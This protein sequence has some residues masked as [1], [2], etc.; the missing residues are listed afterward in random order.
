MAEGQKID[1]LVRQGMKGQRDALG[2]LARNVEGRV[3]AYLCRVTLSRALTEDL[4]QEVLLTM[5]SSLG[6]LKD[7]DRFWPWLYRIAQSKIQQHFRTKQRHPVAPESRLYEELVARR[8]DRHQ[9]DGLKQL[10]HKD[11]VKKTLAAM[12]Q[13]S[14]PHRAV[15]SLRCFDELSYGDIAL[16][17][18]CSEVKARVLFYRAKEALK[19]QL[20]RQGVKKSM[21]VLC[22]GLFGKITAPAD[23]AAATVTVAAG[24]MKAGLT[25]ALLANLT[26]KTVV[27]IVGAITL[28]TATVGTVS[29]LSQP[30][31]TPRQQVTS[32]HFTTQLRFSGQGALSSLS[33]GAYEQW[34]H[35][36]AGVD[37]PVFFRMQR[38]DPLQKNKLCAWLQDGQANYYF[39][40]G[41]KKLYLSND[42][43]CWSCLKVRRL[44]TDNA[45]FTDFLDS[46]EGRDPKLTYRRDR[47]SGLLLAAV[48]DRFADARHFRTTYEY[49]TA[50]PNAFEPNW[51]AGTPVVDNRDEMHRRGWT[52]FTIRGRLGDR[53]V[54]GRGR[55]PFVYDASTEHPAWMI[56]EAGQTRIV[57]GSEIARVENTGGGAPIFYPGGSFFAGLARPWMGLHCVDTVRRDAVRQRIAFETGKAK[58][59]D[60]A[61]VTLTHTVGT[62]TVGLTYV[63]AMDTDVVDEIRFAINRRPAG[64]LRFSYL[65][66]IDA[67]ADQFVEPE[68]PQE[69]STRVAESPGL[70][71]LIDLALGQVGQQ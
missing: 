23:A 34:F 46:M 68:R 42:R 36:P 6:D 16:T 20:G 47:R 2:Q 26:I 58:H 41:T 21:L 3:S 5:V 61:T 12:R 7:P 54:S 18:N 49:N 24:S 38:W 57:D 44:P 14:E 9:H 13:L 56:L 17:M 1:I 10:M 51:P 40:S 11:L 28:G 66:E 65:Q 71:W 39:E 48:D 37:G 33:K 52:F 19:K 4:T 35:F 43:V 45:A 30:T 64:A 27:L 25:A 8:A 32:L 67:V 15:L 22:L 62:T 53:T 63:L 50:E 60:L 69:V 70:T 59:G 29:K 55:V 31:L